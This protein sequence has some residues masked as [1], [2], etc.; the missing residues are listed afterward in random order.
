VQKV[1]TA[2]CLMAQAKREGARVVYDLD[3]DYIDRVQ[4]LLSC[5]DVVTV[6]SRELQSRIPGSVL[7]DDALDWDGT[8]AKPTRGM[9]TVGWLGGVDNLPTLD[10]VRG[11][12]AKR[13][14]RLVT[15][16][17][18][19]WTLA[20]QDRRLAACG[21]AIIP[22]FSTPYG[23][24]KG[25]GRLLK[26]WALG[27]PV[28]CSPIPAYVDAVCEA[29][30]DSRTLIYDWAGDWVFPAPDVAGRIY[31]LTFT[32]QRLAEQWRAVLER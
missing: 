15:I 7:V 14:K 19:A 17:A 2:L 4:A 21:A 31:A 16:C 13:G 11:A 27:L 20:D 28:V 3:D 18:P 30:A 29:G 1:P 10:L 26:A 23:T 25:A 22:Q 32:A 5:A 12:L 9:D 24:A 8:I 6:G